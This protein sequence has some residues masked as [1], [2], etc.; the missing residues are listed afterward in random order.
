M[1]PKK[2]AILGLYLL[3]GFLFAS[4]SAIGQNDG[5][6][7]AALRRLVPG[8]KGKRNVAVWS[9]SPGG[10]AGFVEGADK[11]FEREPRPELM[12]D[13][14]WLLELMYSVFYEHGTVASEA[15]P[16]LK[17]IVESDSHYYWDRADAAFLLFMHYRSLEWLLKSMIHHPYYV[18]SVPVV[19]GK[20]EI[21]SK[22]VQRWLL[23]NA[24]RDC[25]SRLLPPDV[26]G[27]STF[28][29]AFRLNVLSYPE[30]EEFWRWAMS[31]W[32]AGDDLEIFMSLYFFG[33]YGNRQGLLADVDKLMR[34]GKESGRGDA[35]SLIVKRALARGLVMKGEFVL[36][37]D[38][39]L[40]LNLPASE[41]E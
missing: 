32:K 41:V 6:E 2:T 10:L 22:P 27:E 17:S 5:D 7:I 14:V 25:S 1:S 18:A 19:C 20:D 3:F 16:R 12:E 26:G 15:T 9:S 8:V 11:A 36:T 37:D 35:I 31:G 39:S 29:P 30:Y 24:I 23:E 28:K 38:R 4:G 34:L 40:D 21:L 13:R 33:S